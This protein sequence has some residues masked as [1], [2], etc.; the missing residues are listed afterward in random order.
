[1]YTSKHTCN[2][3]RGTSSLDVYVAA[4][5]TASSSKSAFHGWRWWFIP[6]A[7]KTL[8]VPTPIGAWRAPTAS[9]HDLILQK[10]WRLPRYTSV[11]PAGIIC[12]M[13]WTPVAM[14]SVASSCVAAALIAYKLYRDWDFRVSSVRCLFL[15]FFVYLWLY[16]LGRLGYYVWVVTLPTAQ[17][18]DSVNATPLTPEQLDK[19]GIYIT[20]DIAASAKAGVTAVLCFCDV[21]HF[22]AAF[23][24]LPLTYE[25]SEIA[26]KSMDRGIA[27]E[28]AKIRFFML[29]GHSLI[30]A[31]LVTE[32]VLTMIHGGYSLATYRLVMCIYI[33]QI[34]TIVYMV[35][36]LFFLRR[37]G[38]DIEPV[39]GHF[40]ASPVY[41]RLKRT[42]MVYAIMAFQFEV[43]SLC[44]YATDVIRDNVVLRYIGVS[45]VIYNGTGL[46]LALLT[47]CSL[48]CVLRATHWILPHDVESELMLAMENS[49]LAR[50]TV[51]E[52]ELAPLQDPVFV[53]TDIESSSAL[54]AVGDGRIMQR[55]TQIH[56]DILRKTLSSYRG[57]EITTAGDSFQ[58]AFH[59]VREAV[60]YCL[61]VQMQLLTT[62]WPKE[63]H[64]LVPATRK[65]R[66]GTRLIFRGLRVR[67]GVHD[68]DSTDGSLVLNT[69]AVTGKMTYTGAS[70]EIANEICDLGEGGQILV[71]K[72]VAQWLDENKWLFT[73]HP[74]VI[75]PLCDH[76]IPHVKAH[77]ELYQVLPEHV[78]KRRKLFDTLDAAADNYP[79]M[80]S[81]AS[82]ATLQCSPQNEQSTS[83]RLTL[84]RKLSFS[85]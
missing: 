70:M 21:M 34:I 8:C 46:A 66:S 15:T 43:T 74:F 39:D 67:M 53:V 29:S 82:E 84:F 27:K 54:W 71:T 30:V 3:S 7:P 9:S 22:A 38:R 45:Q 20:L 19:L 11:Q 80:C 2:R 32:I 78:A 28:K 69:H 35:A 14:A 83:P 75:H 16:T 24:V 63:L 65:I 47:G 13:I 68:A 49:S 40:E 23:W 4:K 60:M 48:P 58:L 85:L 52:V 44:V 77:L 33:M 17:F 61:D 62:S 12:I 1:M 51:S 41:L 10:P 73:P 37:N 56:D 50:A 57:Y 31:F 18:Y 81:T 26:A 6:P 5:G 76:A 55:A 36:L 42:M 79:D 64:A 25:L 59:T 72:R